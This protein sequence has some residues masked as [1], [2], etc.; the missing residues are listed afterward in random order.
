MAT[1]TK[2][3]LRKRSAA[4]QRYRTRDG[5][6]VPGVTTITGMVGKEAL[7]H[8]AWKLGME[9]I[10]YRTYRDAAAAV[11][12][13][14]HAMVEAHIKGEQIDLSTYD[15]ET[16]DLAEN[17]FLKF[18]EWEKTY[19][20]KY[21]FSERQLVS[22]E[23]RY[24]GTLDCYAEIDGNPWLIDFKTGKAIYED[25]GFQLAAYAGLLTDHGYKV[26]GARI[27]R[28]GR[29]EDEGFEDRV[30]CALEPYYRGFRSLL[31]FYYSKKKV[32]G[33]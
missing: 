14:A 16:I 17:G 32:S 22:D 29:N 10:D 23:H 15:P 8:W 24:G 30:F 31:D 5:K 3:P 33:R 7:I 26:Y 20:P 25:M 6:I 28:I 27:L 21:I 18:L 1:K 13:L 19:E 11:G 4:H 9:G 12:T 2:D